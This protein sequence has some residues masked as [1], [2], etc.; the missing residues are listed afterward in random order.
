MTSGTALEYH[1]WTT[2]MAA[3]EEARRLGD[4]SIGTEHLLLG[5]LRDPEIAALV[6]VSHDD[7]RAAL[8]KQ[9]REALHAVGLDRVP[10][11]PPIDERPVP[12]R[13]TVRAVMGRR[14]KMTPAAKSALKRAGRP[15]R[16]G[17]HITAQ[18]VLGELLECSAPDP[19]AVLL[20]RL[21]VDRVA[22]RSRLQ[23]DVTD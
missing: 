12:A 18:E 3:R 7:A 16:R 8:D 22:L 19:S 1:P 14:L 13:P 2:F 4:R 10:A 11:P 6:G 5:L 9:D 20:E 17:R 15:M 23:L 21:G